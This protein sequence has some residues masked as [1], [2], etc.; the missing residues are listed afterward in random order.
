MARP[1]KLQVIISKIATKVDGSIT[2]A[3][4]TRELPGEDAATLF[5]LRNKEAWAILAPNELDESSIP[6]EKAESGTGA[7]TPTS[8]LRAVLFV[9]WKQKGSQGDFEGFYKTQVERI[10][11]SIKE[12][13]DS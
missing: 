5:T 9:Y 2:V 12:K 6:K 11:D 13:L 1:V 8:R 10:I 7:K 4:E 3:M